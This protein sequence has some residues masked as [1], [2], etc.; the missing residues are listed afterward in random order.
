MRPDDNS[1]T[2]KFV[3]VDGVFKKIADKAKNDDKNNYVIVIDEI[4]R[5]NISKVLGELITL[6]EDDKRWG[7]TNQLSTRLPSGELFVVPNNLYVIGTMNSADKSISLID[8]ALRRRF[9]FYEV[10]V[11][12]SKITNATL[13]EVLKRINE[14]L[15]KQLETSD[16]LIGHAYFMDKTENDLCNVLNHKVIPLLYEYFFDA[17]EKVKGILVKALD[18]FDYEPKNEVGRRLRVVK[19]GE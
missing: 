5:A 19:K 2:L 13:R 18:G 3:P 10:S 7:E 16:L 1:E 14:D 12:Y 15:E 11:D 6:L 4:N 8:A 9:D 17:K